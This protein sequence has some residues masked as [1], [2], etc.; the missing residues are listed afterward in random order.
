M[1]YDQ[2][3]HQ[4]N[5][6]TCGPAALRNAFLAHG[7]RVDVR[8]VIKASGITK[9]TIDTLPGL[10]AAAGVFGFTLVQKTVHTPEELFE[11]LPHYPPAL[12]CIDL[13]EHWV[14]A[15][16]TSPRFITVCDPAR[17]GELVQKWPWRKLA[18]WLIWGLPGEH[19]M[20]FYPVEE[21]P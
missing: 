18:E 11:A 10:R 19:R 8:R 4:P 5:A 12:L 9:T 15:L 20:D 17:G 21:A 2:L 1:R 3:R 7:T 6:W 14:T 16:D 13:Y